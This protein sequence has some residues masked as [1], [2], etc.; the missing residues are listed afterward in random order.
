MMKLGI[1][2]GSGFYN[3]NAK[4]IETKNITTEY[5]DVSVEI[6]EIGNKIVAHIPRHGKKHELISTM[7]NHKA[8]IMALS[9]LDVKLII[10]TTV[11]GITNKDLGL[12]KLLLFNDIFFIDN[13][14]PNGEVC[15]FFTKKGDKKRGH[16]IFNFPF[17]QRIL[18]KLKS[19]DTYSNLTYGHMNGPRFNSKAEITFIKNYAD[20]ISQTCGPEVMFSG[21]LEIPYILLGFGVDYANG[22]QE[23][24]TP[25]E[26]LQKHMEKSKTVFKYAIEKIITLDIEPKFEG[27]VYRFE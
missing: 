6:T 19:N 18:D 27:F 24:P 7:I 10:G 15:T 2:T 11:C 23:K 5:G 14:L 16:Y 1:I 21:E 8:N 12:G 26:V 9:K 17:N 22:I 13:R 4:I 20:G 25:I 3:L